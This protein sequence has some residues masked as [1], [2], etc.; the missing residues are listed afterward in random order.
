MKMKSKE[1]GGLVHQ[2]L[3]PNNLQ[4]N[5]STPKCGF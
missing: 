1:F 5:L 4:H 2:D 3:S